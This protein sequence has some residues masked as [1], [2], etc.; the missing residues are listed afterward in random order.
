MIF[1]PRP[2]ISN[3]NFDVKC[4]ILPFI[5]FVHDILVHL[6]MA[7]SGDLN[8]VFLQMGQCFGIEKGEEVLVRFFR[9]TFTIFGIT[10]PALSI[11]TVSPTLISLRSISS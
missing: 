9:I 6:Q 4:C 11:K 3:A 1:S 2:S 10:S 7:S 5:C 8:A